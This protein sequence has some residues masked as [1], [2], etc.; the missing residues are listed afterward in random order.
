[1]TPSSATGPDH[2]DIAASHPDSRRRH[3]H[4]PLVTPGGG[5]TMSIASLATIVSA[6]QAGRIVDTFA[7]A[8]PRPGS[9]MST[10][11]TPCAARTSPGDSRRRI[12]QTARFCPCTRLIQALTGHLHINTV[13]LYHQGSSGSEGSGHSIR[14]RCRSAAS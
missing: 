4:R 14:P 3:R 9:L 6:N 2:M 5:L 10:S 13:T 12:P 11:A 8:S 1:M 7:D